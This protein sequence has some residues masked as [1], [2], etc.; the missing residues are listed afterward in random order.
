MRATKQGLESAEAERQRRLLELQKRQDALVDQLRA[1]LVR[2]QRCRVRETRTSRAA[3][4]EAR[5]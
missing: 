5:G 1:E 2:A 4:S 3:G